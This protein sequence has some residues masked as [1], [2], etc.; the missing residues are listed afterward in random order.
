MGVVD[1]RVSTSSVR[2]RRRCGAC[3][4]RVT[5]YEVT[6]FE[7]R[8]IDEWVQ[9]IGEVREFA[10]KLVTGLDSLEGRVTRT[11]TES[12]RMRDMTARELKRQGLDQERGDPRAR[13]R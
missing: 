3:N 6:A 7:K 9:R 8:L 4:F 13:F 5:T 11:A 2:R 10:H 1:S 12:V